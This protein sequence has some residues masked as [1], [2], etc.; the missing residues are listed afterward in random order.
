MQH[1]NTCH[2]CQAFT[3]KSPD[4]VLFQSIQIAYQ[5]QD[6]KK[7]LYLPHG[8]RVSWSISPSSIW[9]HDGT[10]T[11]YLPKETEPEVDFQIFLFKPLE[12]REGAKSVEQATEQTFF[13]SNA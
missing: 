3:H 2:V 9:D 12:P 13:L 6:L 7:M 4:K 1:G 11:L 5:S 8:M 10:Q